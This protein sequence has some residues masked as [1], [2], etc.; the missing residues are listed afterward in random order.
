MGQPVLHPDGSTTVQ[1][2]DGSATTTWSDG[3][4]QVDYPD[5]SLMITYP[6]RR[7]YNQYA[8]GTRTLNDQFGTPL[9][10]DTGLP[11]QPDP[12]P[13]GPGPGTAEYAEEVLHGAHALSSVAEAV[14]IVADVE[15]VAAVAAESVDGLLTVAV[16]AFE[17]WKA[18]D[19]G[20]RAYA[21]AGHCYGLLYGPLGLDGPAYPAGG[22][23]L[24]SDD[25]IAEKQERFAEGVNQARAELANG[26]D[27]IALRNRILLRTAHLGSDPA[28]TLDEVWQ[29]SCR[30]VDNEFYADHMRLMWPD[31]GI[32]ER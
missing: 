12:G 27:G 10:P 25:T 22:W 31:T 28:A 18:F 2:D 23:S 24:D 11:L 14:T 17:G 9:D 26:A 16:L 7:V 29:A 15:G 13:Y 1:D 5:G 6:D 30:M 32:T 3:T 21:T 4:V 8:D 19:S 20:F